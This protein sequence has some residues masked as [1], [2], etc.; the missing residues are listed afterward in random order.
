MCILAPVLSSTSSVSA[1]SLT[2]L[3]NLY[4][5]YIISSS[6]FSVTFFTVNIK[7]LKISALGFEVVG[8]HLDNEKWIAGKC[9]ESSD[10]L[11]GDTYNT[12]GI[13]LSATWLS[14]YKNS[15]IYCVEWCAP[16]KGIYKGAELCFSYC[17]S[18]IHIKGN[19][20]RCSSASEKLL[21]TVSKW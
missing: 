3:R 4:N 13:V 18:P 6:I 21:S 19:I 16:V 14:T 5:L 17:F 12:I 9:L 11:E 8:G 20:P 1:S 7:C 2:N 10:L 15:I